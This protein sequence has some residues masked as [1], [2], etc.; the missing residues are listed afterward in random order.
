[1]EKAEREP[2]LLDTREALERITTL[3]GKVCDAILNIH[4]ILDE[5]IHL[6]S[7]ATSQ[8]VAT[9]ESKQAANFRFDMHEFANST[10]SNLEKT[11]K[12]FRE[13]KLKLVGGK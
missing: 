7:S 3:S 5:D 13:L 8:P 4:C 9:Q 11:L 2:T 12:H 6:S 1:M 10:I